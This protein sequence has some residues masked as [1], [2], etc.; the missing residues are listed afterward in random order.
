[1]APLRRVGFV[2]IGVCHQLRAPSPVLQ[3]RVDDAVIFFVVFADAPRSPVLKASGR[4]RAVDELGH[5]AQR[6]LLM[7]DARASLA[8]RWRAAGNPGI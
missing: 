1:M 8:Y 7:L 5:R 3:W 4:G 6:F 2:P